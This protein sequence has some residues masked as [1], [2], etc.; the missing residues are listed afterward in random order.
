MT[1]A[2]RFTLTFS[3]LSQVEVKGLKYVNIIKKTNLTN[4]TR[5]DSRPGT[6]VPEESSNVSAGAGPSAPV[7]VR[8]EPQ[9]VRESLYEFGAHN[10]GEK[11]AGPRV[12]VFSEKGVK[13]VEGGTQPRRSP[14]SKS[15][16]KRKRESIQSSSPCQPSL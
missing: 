8:Q 12:K 14:R 15:I 2:G 5:R 4:K 16:L 3:I 1:T 10:V 9:I 7:A 13:R 11:L 6:N